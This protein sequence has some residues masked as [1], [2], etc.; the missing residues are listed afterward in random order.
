[1]LRF[2]VKVG[3]RCSNIGVSARFNALVA[4]GSFQTCNLKI[5][6]AGVNTGLTLENQ[7]VVYRSNSTVGLAGET[8]SGRN[9]GERVYRNGRVSIGGAGH[10]RKGHARA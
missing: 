6:R 1:M 9:R 2:Y 10:V 3:N 4:T 5:I 8:V 7:N